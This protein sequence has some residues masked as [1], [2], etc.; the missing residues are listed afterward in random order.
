MT[1]NTKIARSNAAFRGPLTRGAAIA[2]WIAA[3]LGTLHA[4]SSAY[5]AFGGMWLLESV[6]QWAAQAAREGSFVVTVG[7]LAIAL[8]KLAAAWIPLLAQAGRVPGLRFWRFLGW[9]GGPALVLYGGA[10]AVVGSAALAGWIDSEI[11]DQQAMMGHAYIWGP[12]FA[13]WGI[14]LTIALSL[15]RPVKDNASRS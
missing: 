3:V 12:H 4:A 15:S 1:A 6:G 8:V 9:I 10:N 5:W 2:F 7:L 13:L 11:V 14:A